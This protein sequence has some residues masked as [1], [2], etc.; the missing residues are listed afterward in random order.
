VQQ[1]RLLDRW[2]KRVAQVSLAAIDAGCFGVA[3]IRYNTDASDPT[4]RAALYTGPFTVE[5]ATTTRPCTAPTTMPQRRSHNSQDDPRSTRPGRPRRSSNGP[6]REQ[7]AG[8]IWPR[9]KVTLAATD[10]GSG[11]AAIRPSP[12]TGLRIRTPSGTPLLRPVHRRRRHVHTIMYARL[13][14]RRPTWK[15]PTRKR[16]KG[17][18]S[19]TTCGSRAG[20]DGEGGGGGGASSMQVQQRDMFRRVGYS[21]SVQGEPWPRPTAVPASAC[22]PLTTTNTGPDPTPSEATL[23]HLG[24]INV[25]ADHDPSSTAGLR[26]RRQR[27]DRPT[28]KTIQIDTIAPTSSI[29]LQQRDKMF[30]RVVQRL[31]PR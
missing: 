18:G 10:R 5:A 12:P 27:R 22:D 24:T 26:H 31:R 9:S 6:R 17:G 30:D 16:S 25:A 4:P 1:R 14:H 2:Y 7:P 8:T 11:V 23:L 20:G 19:W 21:A 15:P 3:A 29:K 13:R 28:R